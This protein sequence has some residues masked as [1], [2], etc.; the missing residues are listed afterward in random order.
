MKTVAI[1]K[2]D[3]VSV[4]PTAKGMRISW[5]EHSAD[6]DEFEVTALVAALTQEHR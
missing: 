3:S 5:R 6:L 1:G 4:E 2:R